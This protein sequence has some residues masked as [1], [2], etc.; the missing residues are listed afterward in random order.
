MGLHVKYP[1][2]LSYFNKPWIFFD[3]FSKNTEISI[4]M[5]IR[6]VGAELF[7]ADPGG[8]TDM[9]KLIVAFRD[10]ANASRVNTYYLSKSYISVEVMLQ[11]IISGPL[12]DIY[13]TIW[14]VVLLTGKLYIKT[15]GWS[16]NELNLYVSEKSVK[17]F[18]SG[19]GG[20]T[21]NRQLTHCIIS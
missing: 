21:D 18:Q 3:S 1:L 9:T 20:R 15:L 10:F 11:Y 13:T 5:K 2:F 8:R 14:K 16:P 4:F 7:Y 17:C 12:S 6:P 19:N